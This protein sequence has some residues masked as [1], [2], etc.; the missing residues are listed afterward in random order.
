WH[1]V[2]HCWV[3]ERIDEQWHIYLQLRS[4]LKKDYP[5]QFDI[6]AAGHLLADETVE[7][8]IREL[9]EELGVDAAFSDLHPLGVIAYKIENP[10]I[11]DF[12]FA[13]VF[14]YIGKNG[15][16]QFTIQ[17]SELDGMYRL[18]LEQ[19]VQFMNG[20]EEQAVVEG[21]EVV[22]KEKIY[23]QK[24]ITLAKMETLPFDYRT[25]LVEKIAELMDKLNA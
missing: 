19:F 21:Y 11:K 22:N 4:K 17:E 18:P 5:R 9:K 16:D 2:F 25:P 24:I 3:L 23:G 1:E 15:F 10:F 14:C 8:G 7:D 13:H 6:T 20:K 12:E